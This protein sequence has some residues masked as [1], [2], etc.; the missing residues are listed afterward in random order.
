MAERLA[1]CREEKSDALRLAC[2]DKET[3]G[4]TNAPAKASN[5]ASNT[6]NSEPDAGDVGEFGVA[7]S[8]IARQ[9]EAAQP[10][11]EQQPQRLTAKVTAIANKPHGELIVTLDN[12][13]VWTQKT[14]GPYF[15]LKVGDEVTISAGT[16]GS[17]RLIA[18]GRAT[19]VT[20]VE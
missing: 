18:S 12:G 1:Q 2:F 15:P 16:L 9:R 8:Q 5:T 14:A 7:G 4:L 17:Y 10:A 19:P 6:K 20:R 13:Q 3:A 11:K